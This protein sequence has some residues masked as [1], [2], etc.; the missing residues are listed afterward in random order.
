MFSDACGWSWRGAQ[1]LRHVGPSCMADLVM[2][3]LDAPPPAGA[4][5][6]GKL[7][8]A[9][10]AAGAG[11]AAG[12]AA[13]QARGK[14]AKKAAAMVAA[15]AASGVN[16]TC[17][18]SLAWWIEWVPCPGKPE[19]EPRMALYV[20]DEAFIKEALAAYPVSFGCVYELGCCAGC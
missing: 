11:A 4:S 14:A 20:S 19:G 15:V 17:G 13:N 8:T 9:N 6:Q 12:A 16:A 7:S 5:E 3:G 10:V 1:V 2:C 18:S